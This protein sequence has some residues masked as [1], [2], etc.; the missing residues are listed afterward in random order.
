[1]KKSEELPENQ[2]E[3]AE[4]RPAEHDHAFLDDDDDEALLAHLRSVHALDSPEH[5][6]RT[7]LQGLHDRVHHETDAAADR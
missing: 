4:E 6:S 2:I 7:T 5:M 3:E 1:V